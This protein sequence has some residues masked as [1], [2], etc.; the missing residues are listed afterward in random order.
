MTVR[1]ESNAR[2]AGKGVVQP[3]VSS[4]TAATASTGPSPPKNATAA[5]AVV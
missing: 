5:E 2:R 4:V 3:R 1:A